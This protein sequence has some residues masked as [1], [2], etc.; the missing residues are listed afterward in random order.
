MGTRVIIKADQKNNR[1]SA[2][3]LVWS[4][5]SDSVIAVGTKREIFRWLLREEAAR[6]KRDL[7]QTFARAD[8]NGSSDRSIRFAWWGEGDDEIRIR[9]G[10]PPAPD[11]FE[12]GSWVL[13]R[14]AMPA[15]A[16]ALH[17]GDRQM[18]NS[19]LT[20]HPYEDDTAG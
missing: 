7:E 8:E 4:S 15:Y 11:P 10:A 9:E 6:A 14:T 17:S 1:P 2:L 18:A 19:L 13:T 5:G 3:Y 12:D 20:F 16:R